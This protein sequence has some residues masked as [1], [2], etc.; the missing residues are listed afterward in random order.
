M[1]FSSTSPLFVN[2]A[3]FLN[4]ATGGSEYIPGLVSIKPDAME[5]VF[6][7]VLGGAGAFAKRVFDTSTNTVPALLQGDFENLELNNVPLVRKLYGNVSERVTFEDYFDKVNHVLTRGEELKF[8]IKQGDPQQVRAVRTKY[9]DEL[10]IYPMVRALANRRNKLAAELRKVRENTKMP[11]EQ[12]RRR[13]EILQ[14]QIEQITNRVT[15]AY[16]QKVGDKY[17]GLFS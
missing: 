1:Y 14:K 15:K 4:S 3:D 6:D 11:P 5:Y 17:P 2:V 10:S 12:K 16:D 8:A 9:A 13:Q 7:Y